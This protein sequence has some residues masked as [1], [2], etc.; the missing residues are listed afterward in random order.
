MI[1]N[2]YKLFFV[3]FYLFILGKP[4][5]FVNLKK[6]PLG[7]LFWDLI[8]RLNIYL[9]PCFFGRCKKNIIKYM[10][11]HT[12]FRLSQ[13]NIMTAIGLKSG[14]KSINWASVGIL[15]TVK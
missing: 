11:S 3:Y 15:E 12:R 10:Y 14:K 2:C 8:Y 9:K 6:R 1:H 4:F 7:I 13:L 5:F